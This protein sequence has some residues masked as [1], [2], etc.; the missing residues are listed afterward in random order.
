MK[1][2]DLAEEI[3]RLSVDERIRLIEEIW[4]SIPVDREP[5]PLSTAQ[6]NE[7]D[8]RIESYRRDPSRAI[9]AEEAFAQ[10]RERFG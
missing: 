3:R 5:P 6:R 1:T 2:I 9:L 4:E 8:R 10:L 7:L